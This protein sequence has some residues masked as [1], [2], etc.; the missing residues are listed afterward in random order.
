MS[1]AIS[2]NTWTLL[3]SASDPGRDSPLAR[4]ADLIRRKSGI[5]VLSNTNTILQSIYEELY[6]LLF[7]IYLKFYP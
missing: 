4:Q 6:S 2:E 7:N 5:D 1:E 3:K